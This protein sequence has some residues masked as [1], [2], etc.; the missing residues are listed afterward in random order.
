[1][2]AFLLAGVFMAI[3]IVALGFWGLGI[4]CII[5]IWIKIPT[6]FFIKVILSVAVFAL[7]SSLSTI[8]LRHANR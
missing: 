3:M 5:E 4:Y 7:F 6:Y 8:T 1:M 2:K